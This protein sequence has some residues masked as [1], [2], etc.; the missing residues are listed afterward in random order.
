MKIFSKTLLQRAAEMQLIS[1]HEIPAS[2]DFPTPP[3]PT[4]PTEGIDEKQL[5]ALKE[6][7]DVLTEERQRHLEQVLNLI[8]TIF[9]VMAALTSHLFLL[10]LIDLDVSKGNQRDA[11][12]SYSE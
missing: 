12:A 5:V 3:L 10:A 8:V 9:A 1:Y 6:A 4:I 2:L 11:R 7:V